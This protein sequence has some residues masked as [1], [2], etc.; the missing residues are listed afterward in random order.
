VGNRVKR[1]EFIAVGLGLGLYA[2]RLVA[3]LW[4][5]GWPPVV[6]LLLIGVGAAVGV[7]L[8]ALLRRVPLSWT[9]LLALWAYVL[10]PRINF[11]VA[12]A[13]GFIAVV[14]TLLVNLPRPADAAQSARRRWLTGALTDAAVFLFAYALYRLT[15][16]PTVLPADA[17]EF[18]L[19]ARVLGVAHPFG[20]PLYTLL[21]ACFA[22]LPLTADVAA[23]VSL[24]SAVTGALTLAVISRTARRLTGSA[25]GGLAA[26]LAL[27][28]S[29]TF[30]AQ[31]TTANIRSLTVLFTALCI[32]TLVVYTDGRKPTNLLAFAT[33]LG[34][35]IAHHPSLAFFIPVFAAV[36]LLGDPSPFRQRRF[37]LKFALAFL[38][39]FLV[40]L[41]V[42]IRAWTGAPF[43]TGE[44]TSF[45]R[46]IDHLVGKGFSGDMFY[47]LG[48]P[49]LPERFRI[50]GGILMFQFGGPLLAIAALGGV[51]LVW[52]RRRVAVLLIGVFVVMGFIVATYR[53]PQSVE[54]FM[55]AYVPVA[56]A[57]GCATGWLAR[58]RTHLPAVNAL[59]VAVIL[60]LVV[61]LGAANYPDYVVL[62][63]DTDAR[64]Y[65]ASLLSTAPDGAVILANW[66][67]FTPLKYLQQVE[68]VRPD[69][70]VSY[71]HPEG[72]PYAQT[73]ARR[74]GEEIG[75]R[76][77]VVTN[78]Y[79]DFG[80]LPYRFVPLGEAFLVQEGPVYDR[81][82][83]LTPLEATFGGLVSVI[84]YRLEETALPPG[85]V[86]T[87]DLAWGPPIT[88][89]HP[90]AFFVHLVDEEG[91]PL[92][93]GDVSHPGAPNYVPGEVRVDRFT[94]PV[95]TT[96]A[97]G[98]Y[99]LVAGA[100]IPLA[101]GGWQRLTTPDGMETVL[102]GQVQV[103]PG[104]DAPLTMHPIYQP[105]VGGPTPVGV[106]YDT[107]LP[108][109]RRIYLHWRQP[110][111]LREPCQAVVYAGSEEVARLSL[112]DVPAGTNFTVAC[113]L[114]LEMT[115][116]RLEV[117]TA[118]SEQRPWTG[119]WGWSLRGWLILPITPTESHYVPL[120]GEMVLVGA[121]I[122][123]DPWPAGYTQR[124]VAHWLGVRPLLRDYD[125]SVSLA[126][127]GGAQH[128]SVPALGAVPTLKW[129]GGSRVTD[130]HFL[131]VPADAAPGSASLR[132]TVYDAFTLRPL[133]PLDERI[134]RL[135][136]GA[137]VPLGEVVVGA[138]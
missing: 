67:W 70:D 77:V 4:T 88:L 5:N 53:A 24:L 43:G 72:V 86:L 29:T 68:G 116:L 56:L 93:Q 14:A 117:Q 127:V 26:A 110:A 78:F 62:S 102:L 108:G 130:A 57:V 125:V 96:A 25:L 46:V 61:S 107:T 27:G 134:T 32:H 33:A 11:G 82:P 59:A 10:W 90:I 114:P 58:W 122:P 83:D 17:G 55:P 18:Q 104:T 113:D 101:D 21:G 50:L 126:G 111:Y 35:G 138:R 81:P 36:I 8:L 23:R 19:V 120:S 89:E 100:Y 65:A 131:P 7:N 94:I 1:W 39:P 6:L 42:P 79:N 109:Q 76:P 15:L 74:I 123:P 13:A 54:Y 2:S 30:W 69:V 87:V 52:R 40:V 3:E 115:D 92:G 132:L 28:V 71:V 45:A 133:T 48:S 106:D 118:A 136:M 63:H 95:L 41:Y 97:P 64:D 112:P 98:T 20:F 119:P 84:G 60:L 85:G 91:Q 9:P 34:F 49:L 73:W 22:R 121:D 12:A 47:Y 124:V 128:D 31:S 137:A 129:L 16:T 37:W 66:H 44:L 103:V 135:G 105:T 38:A 75:T 80:A 99:R 51:W